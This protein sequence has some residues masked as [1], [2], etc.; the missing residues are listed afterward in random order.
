MYWFYQSFKIFVEPHNSI[1]PEITLYIR[2]C[3]FT[4]F[5]GIE[6]LT[7]KIAL[8]LEVHLLVKGLQYTLKLE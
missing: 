5:I 2:N 3:T 6:N 4:L 8:E 7:L 1:P